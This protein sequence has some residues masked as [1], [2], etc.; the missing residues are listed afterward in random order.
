MT[1]QLP[2][3]PEGFTVCSPMCEPPPVLYYNNL[4]SL[5]LFRKMGVFGLYNVGPISKTIADAL[6][7]IAFR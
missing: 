7:S 1:V 3:T 5:V 2:Q 4:P 6:A